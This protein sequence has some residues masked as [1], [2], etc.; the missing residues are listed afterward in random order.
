[1]SRTRDLQHPTVLVVDDEPDI[2]SLVV[3]T[4][5]QEGFATFSSSDGEEA[6]RL[7]GGLR[8]DVIVSDIMMPKLNGLHLLQLAK[9]RDPNVEVVLITAYGLREVLVEAWTKGACSLLEKPFSEDQLI[10]AVE[11]ACGRARF[12]R[13]RDQSRRRAVNRRR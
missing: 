7:L 9:E 10:G 5:E 13:Q 2:V 1:M 8:V 4:L 12:R 6:L 11:R 3:E